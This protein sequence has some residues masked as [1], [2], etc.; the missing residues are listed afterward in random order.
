[1]ATLTN[2]H[3][4]PAS[5][6]AAV[7][8][9]PYTGGG[10]IS[11]TKLI[12]SPQVVHLAKKHHDKIV[13]DVSERVWTLLGQAVHTILER[14]GLRQEGMVAEQRLFAEVGGWTL[15]GQFDV[16]DLE[17][18]ALHDYK[19]TT[20]FK[21]KGNDAWTRQLNVLRWLAV[22]NGHVVNT[23]EI[24][25]IFRDWRKSEA[26]KNP[27]YPQAAIQTIPIP[28]W[29][30]EETED[31]IVERVAMHQ[32]AQ[33]GEPAPCSDED[34]WYSGTTYALVKPGQKRAQRLLSVPPAPDEVPDGMEVQRRPG[35][36][37]R[38]Q[39]YC[40]A[41][42]FCAQWQETQAQMEAVDE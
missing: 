36:Y 39:L 28:V 31:Y 18:E 7:Q 14:A 41:S 33:R 29:D 15:S 20:V 38:C 8:N 42:P 5:I 32:A 23:L 40:D 12:D 37:R 17:R 24:V 22:K 3:N 30:L 4:L 27:E 11:V 25:A 10:D 6:V 26:L 21:A 1:M 19:V 2:Q 16:L 13:T 34:R 35:E 9:D